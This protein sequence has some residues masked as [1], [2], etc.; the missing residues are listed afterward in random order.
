VKPTWHDREAD[1][2]RGVGAYLA[3]AVR[4]RD[5]S[6]VIATP[7]HRAAFRDELAAAGLDPAGID[8]DGAVRWLDAATILSHVMPEGRIDPKAFQTVVGDVMREAGQTGREIRAYGEMVALLWDAGDVLGAIE[9]EKLWNGLARELR[10]SLWCAYHGHSLAVHEHADELHEVCHL[11]TCVIDEATA[12]FAAGADGPLAARRFVS[13]VLTRRPY[14]NRV[15]LGDARVV[16]SEL[17]SNAVLHDGACTWCKRSPKRGASTPAQTA[18]PS[19]R[20]FRS[21]EPAVGRVQIWLALRRRTRASI[22][23]ATRS[24]IAVAMNWPAALM[25]ISARP[26]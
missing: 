4:A 2:A 14:E 26:L 13:S 20:S 9:L 21:A 3:Q 12:R 23:A 7:A 6:I 5:T 25:P 19:G 16:V 10:F 17:A 11:H 18:R 1:L 8:G 22:A 15:Y 24:T